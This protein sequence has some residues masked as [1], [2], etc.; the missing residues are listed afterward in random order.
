MSRWI[1]ICEQI[2]MGAGKGKGSASL[3]SL[4]GNSDILRSKR[5]KIRGDIKII[6][7]PD[8]K[9]KTACE[10][11]SIPCTARQWS[12]WQRGIGLAYKTSKGIAA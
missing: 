1:K 9:F 8:G 2:S 11:A 4:P 10:E 7:K 3:T 12:K 5:V 6:Q